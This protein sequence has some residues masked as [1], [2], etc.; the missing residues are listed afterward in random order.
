M[1]RFLTAFLLALP[2][3]AAEEAPKS[4]GPGEVWTVLNFLIL[5]GVL[6]YLIA[7][8]LGPMLAQ[9]SVQIQEGLAAGEKAKAEADARGAAVQAQLSSLGSEIEKLRAAAI[10]D[11]GREAERIKRETESELARIQQHATQEIESA[12]KVATLEV[13]RYAAKLAIELAEQKLR[14]RMSNDV[15]ASLIQNFIGDIAGNRAKAPNTSN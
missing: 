5:V 6:G 4:E 9:R 12:G 7:K 3:V 1:A 10:E 15:Q 2:A 8:N 11:R 14:A 13:R